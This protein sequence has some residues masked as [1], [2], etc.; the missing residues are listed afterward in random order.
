M[1]LMQAG[2]KI[3]VLCWSELTEPPE[4]YPQGTNGAIAEHLR[5]NPELDVRTASML[6]LD[7]GIG[8]EA[9]AWAHVLIW[10]GHRRHKDVDDARVALTV[11]QVRERGL[12]FVAIHSAHFSRIFNRLLGTSCRLGG[13]RVDGGSE[14]LKCVLPSHRIA[15][16]LGDFIIPQTEMY[17]EPFDVPQPE[18]TVFFSHWDTGE[19]FRSCCAWTV[20][21]GRVVYFRPGHETYPIFFQEEPLRVVENSVYWCAQR[22]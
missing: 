3:R 14:H 13:I 19:Q 4:A 7:Q 9:L 8:T 12:G 17:N 5:R 18:H 21:K 20:G 16:G 22:D 6:D 2:G 10:W 1:G 15:Q 11:R